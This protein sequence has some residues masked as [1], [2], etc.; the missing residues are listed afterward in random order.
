MLGVL[1]EVEKA[2]PELLRLQDWQSVMIDY[3]QPH[4][5]RLWRHY[6]MH[7]RV[8][9]HEI[10]PCSPENAYY[11]PHPWPSAMRIVE[12]VYE[13]GV[14]YGT[15]VKAPPEAAKLVLTAGSTYEMT[16]PDGWHYVRPLGSSVLSVMVSG[17]PWGRTPPK[18]P[19]VAGLHP[20]SRCSVQKLQ[21][22]MQRYYC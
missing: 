4:V 11:H 15:G 10:H 2:L 18:Q 12:G 3:E 19:G 13:M 6:G 20:P 21:E 5:L 7:H 9:L 14:G 16:H 17:T 1:E 8:Y 22:A